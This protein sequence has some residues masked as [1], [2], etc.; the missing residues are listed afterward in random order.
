MNDWF[1]SFEKHSKSLLENVSEAWGDG[2]NLALFNPQLLDF[3]S[4]DFKEYLVS[5]L[6]QLSQLS[7]EKERKVI[8]ATSGTTGLPKLVLLN[9]SAINF[10]IMAINNHL[11]LNEGEY[12]CLGG[13]PA[14]HAFGLNL[15]Y[16]NSKKRGFDYLFIDRSEW[17]NLDSILSQIL[18]SGKKLFLPLVPQLI[19]RIPEEFV[20]KIEGVS[21]VG[22]DIVLNTHIDKLKRCFPLMRHTIGYGM[23]EAGPV[24]TH[25]DLSE[26]Q[27]LESSIG[28][29][30]PGI[31]IKTVDSK[32][33][34]KS[35]GQAEAVFVNGRWCL[36][37]QGWVSTEDYVRYENNCLYFLGRE[38]HILNI[39]SERIHAE[40]LIAEIKFHLKK[41][42]NM[43]FEVEGSNIRLV[44]AEEKSDYL[45]RELELIIKKL[46]RLYRNIS[47]EF[48]S[49]NEILNSLGKVP[50]VLNAA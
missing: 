43:H 26:G 30:L 21:I 38:K 35:P 5:A 15:C 28:S 37:N 50:L 46:P 48:K 7:I 3:S 32:L 33:Y 27:L 4:L 47:I 18:A 8:F 6:E 22:G 40:Q 36:L 41:N 9:E 12:I 11:H 31:S 16:L 24:I 42:I 25:T 14:F 45:E 1:I 19:D 2:K 20:S 34:F 10:N 29:A 23:T 49:Y 13:V 17:N 44:V 39:N